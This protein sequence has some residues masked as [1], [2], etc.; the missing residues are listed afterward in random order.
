MADAPRSTESPGR[1]LEVG[2]GEEEAGLR[3]D[4]AL[5]RKL[6]ELSRSRLKQL[7]LSGQVVGSEAAP[8]RI[9]RDPAQRVHAGQ[10]FVV[11]VP[12]AEPATPAAQPIPLEILFEDS[13]L[14]VIDKPAG[15]VVHPA[16]GNPEGTLVNALLAPCGPSP[17]GIGGGRR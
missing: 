5:Q 11:T 4:R 15:M 12:E 8:D 16:P 10:N 17:A 9:P 6:P 14:I 13:S 3:L 1:R 2:I 7:I